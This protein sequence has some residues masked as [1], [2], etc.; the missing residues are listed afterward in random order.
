MD[1]TKGSTDP[2]DKFWVHLCFFLNC[3]FE[4][5]EM[6][7]KKASAYILIP[8]RT[9]YGI[10]TSSK[11]GVPCFLLRLFCLKKTTASPRYQEKKILIR[12]KGQML[13]GL[14]VIWIL[15][16]S[17]STQGISTKT[18]SKTRIRIQRST[19]GLNYST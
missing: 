17:S 12:V 15:L 13:C 5:D 6:F 1:K 4:R 3:L 19:S 11:L 10:V 9:M 14:W 7:I 8:S 18:F 2:V 16:Y